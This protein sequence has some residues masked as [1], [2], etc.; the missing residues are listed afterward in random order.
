LKLGRVSRAYFQKKFGTE[1]SERFA[2]PLQRLRDW[3]FAALDG[4]D[5]CIHREGLLQ[6][7]RLLQEFFLPEHRGTRYV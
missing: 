2:Q 6:I 3:G 5:I 4:D 1:P 7:D